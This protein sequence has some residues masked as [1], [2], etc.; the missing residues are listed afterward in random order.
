MDETTRRDVARLKADENARMLSHLPAAARDA[1]LESLPGVGK[2]VGALRRAEDARRFQRLE[3]LISSVWEEIQRRQINTV[4]GDDELTAALVADWLERAER[5]MREEKRVVLRNFLVN[6]LAEKATESDYD[7]RTRYLAALDFL[8][9]V[10]LKALAALAQ[11][12]GTVTLTSEHVSGATPLEL[13]ASAARLEL[14][15]LVDHA[16][17]PTAIDGTTVK[18]HTRITDCGRRFVRFCL[19]PD[20]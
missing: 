19:T 17:I 9:V 13:S 2:L 6:T 14:F 1:V 5:E 16:A 7:E 15:A 11:Q 8:S 20:H 10:D 3:D 18:G 4:D 12:S